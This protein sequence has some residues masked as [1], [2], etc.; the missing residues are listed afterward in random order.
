MGEALPVFDDLAARRPT[1]EDQWRAIILFGRN[2]AS[3]KFALAKALLEV[4]PSSG[5]L[6]KLEELALP[7]ALHVCEHLR[8][9]DKQAT[10]AS[11]AFLDGCR[12]FNEGAL[13][14]EA[15]RR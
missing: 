2:V 15:S 11:S 8:L 13:D 6:V 7:F 10:S 14:R 12:K 1:L 5:S 9:E 4:K 3:Y